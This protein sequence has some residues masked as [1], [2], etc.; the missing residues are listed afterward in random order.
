MTTQDEIKKTPLG[1]DYHVDQR[2]MII[3][4]AVLYFAQGIPLGFTFFAFPAMLR[5]QGAPLELIAWVPML[6]LP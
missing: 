2:L 3:V 5:T 1:A 4:I 6:G